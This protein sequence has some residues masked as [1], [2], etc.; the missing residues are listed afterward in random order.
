MANGNVLDEMDAYHLSIKPSSDASRYTLMKAYGNHYR[1]IGETNVNTMATY[2]YGVA[3]VFQQAQGPGGVC[4]LGPMQYVGILQDIILLDYGLVSI[5]VVLFKCDWV[6]NE[7]DRRGHPTYKRD[8]DGFLLANF[9]DDEPF[10]FPAQMQQVFYSEELNQPWWK[11]V[12]H[13]EPRSRRVVTEAGEE[14][15]VIQ[16]NVIGVEVPLEIPNVPHNM[17]MVGAIELCGIEA[18][19]AYAKLQMPGEDDDA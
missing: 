6:K 13:K 19:M 14:Q 2:D 9:N 4:A 12:L 8:E 3:S 1:V 18:I 17:A 10:V 11:V 5:P 16:D 7:V 15:T